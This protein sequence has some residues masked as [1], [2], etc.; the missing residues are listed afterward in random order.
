MLN[1]NNYRDKSMIK[2]KVLHILSVVSVASVGILGFGLAN[3]NIE[4][5]DRLV[6]RA[7]DL[8][9]H[10]DA[11]IEASDGVAEALDAVVEEVDAIVEDAID[12]YTDERDFSNEAVEHADEL[13]EAALKISD[14]NIDLLVEVY[15]ILLDAN[16]KM[17]DAHRRVFP[18]VNGGQKNGVLR[19]AL[20]AV[21]N[22]HSAVLFALETVCATFDR[23]NTEDLYDPANPPV[24]CMDTHLDTAGAIG[25]AR[26]AKH[27][28]N[29]ADEAIEAYLGTNGGTLGCESCSPWVLGELRHADWAVE[30]ADAAVE[31]S[32][33]VIEAADAAIEAADKAIEKAD[34]LVE[35][36]G[37]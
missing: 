20:D 4:D 9:E 34:R 1:G 22:A 14:G 11:A 25:S 37:G 12:L 3:A 23:N 17:Y 5:V 7:D 24:P 15:D 21:M 8:T 18:E 13:I 36:A 10:A 2:K 31:T 19:K 26:H 35:A 6:E 32:D 27:E 30:E 16:D 29:H 28:I 33:A